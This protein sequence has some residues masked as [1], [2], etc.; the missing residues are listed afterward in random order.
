MLLGRCSYELN[1]T[2]L[3]AVILTRK[4]FMLSHWKR[5]ASSPRAD[6]FNLLK[7]SF[8]AWKMVFWNKCGE[9][10]RCS[11]WL[12]QQWSSRVE[13]V[14]DYWYQEGWLVPQAQPTIHAEQ[15][16]GGKDT[17]PS[18]QIAAISPPIEDSSEDKTLCSEDVRKG[19]SRPIRHTFWWGSVWSSICL[20]WQR[21]LIT[22][23]FVRFKVCLHRGQFH[24]RLAGFFR[25]HIQIQMAA[26]MSPVGSAACETGHPNNFC[27]IQRL[28]YLMTGLRMWPGTK[29]SQDVSSD[30]S[31]S[32]FWLC[33][34]ASV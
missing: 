12:I 24:H 29:S 5:S 26:F 14:E 13:M 4:M 33:D 16:R 1:Y 25:S 6:P 11:C 21:Q 19:F 34:V 23:G 3:A 22:A 15:G 17:S 7:V 2:S 30:T 32:D 9:S 31:G 10:H 20:W 28:R 27:S 18:P 8:L